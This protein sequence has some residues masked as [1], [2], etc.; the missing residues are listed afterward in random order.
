MSE[1]A[2]V[3][4]VAELEAEVARLTEILNS[5]LYRVFLD[6]VE[7]EAAYQE[8]R[9]EEYR[10]D[11]KSATDWYLTLGFLAGKARA[12]HLAGD[13]EKVLH[14]TVSSAAFL[15]HWHQAV[16]DDAGDPVSRLL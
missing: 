12:A 3:E 7:R 16:L 14:H 1:D 5:P 6:S 2:N 9:Q 15:L 11:G 10:D 4:R 13:Y 8:Y